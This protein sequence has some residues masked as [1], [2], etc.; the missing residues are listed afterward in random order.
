M[1]HLVNKTVYLRPTGNAAVKRETEVYEATVNSVSKVFVTLTRSDIQREEKLRIGFQENR[2][3]NA[4]NSG[5]VV[6][7]SEQAAL[8]SIEIERL[9]GLIS[10]KLR[11]VNEVSKYP[12]ET[13]RAIDALIRPKA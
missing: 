3:D 10:E 4:H 9:S 2:L 1:K 13:L 11:Y 12:L 5:Y 7:E 8:D 6:Y